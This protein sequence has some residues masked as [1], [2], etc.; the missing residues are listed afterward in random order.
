MNLGRVDPDSN[1]EAGDYV[2][3]VGAER[4]GF[5]VGT[6]DPR[7][8]EK[9]EQQRESMAGDGRAS[10]RPGSMLHGSGSLVWPDQRISLRDSGWVTETSEIASEFRKV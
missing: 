9:N 3:S 5:G 10:F 2:K 6:E 4:V 7:G 1:G 8:R